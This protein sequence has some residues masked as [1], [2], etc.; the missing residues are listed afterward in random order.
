MENKNILVL[1]EI[2][3]KKLT[4]LSKELLTKGRTMSEELDS[5]LIALAI[6][7]KVEEDT[8]EEIKL[9]GTDKFV[10]VEHEE[11]KEYRTIPHVKAFNA[12]I[13]AIKPYAILIPATENGKDIAGRICARRNIG[14]VAECAE[15]ELSED[16]EDIKWIRPSFDGAMFSDIRITTSP[17]I[18]TVLEGVYSD[19]KVE[20]RDMKIENLEIEITQ[21]EIL[22]EIL[23]KIVSK[24]K[25]QSIET[26]DVLVAG[27][28]GLE[29]PEN[30]KIVRELAE[31]LNA[32]LVG[33]KP[34]ADRLWIGPDQFIGI[35]GKTVKPKLYI[36]VG[37]SG[38]YQHIQAMRD[39]Q[40][41]IAINNDPKAPIFEIAHYKIV[42]DLFEIVP[43]LTKA[44]NDMK[45]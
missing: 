20:P 32:P 34:L 14:L 42:G 26:A 17:K 18:G 2:I 12:G 33:S 45:N 25:P 31:A 23:G 8:I 43:K 44:I 5:E 16:K 9:R 15:V 6:S 27:G 1:V 10:K 24:N 13:D 19:K 28:L 40:I 7:D 38:A 37:I 3:D 22:T 41:I 30:V 11:L 4:Q 36:A 39:S 29:M 21:D 35:S